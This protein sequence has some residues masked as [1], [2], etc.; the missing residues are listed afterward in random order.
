[1]KQQ[2]KSKRHYGRTGNSAFDSYK[3][4]SIAELEKEMQRRKE[5]L[6]EEESHFSDFVINLQKSKDQAEFD[7]FMKAQASAA[8]AAEQAAKETKAETDSE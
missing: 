1:M 2:F 6:K 4:D 7:Q 3:A 5:Q 8:K